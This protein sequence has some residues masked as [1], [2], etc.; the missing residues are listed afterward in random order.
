MALP[1]SLN[2]AYYPDGSLAETI[3]TTTSANGLDKTIVT[4]DGNGIV[5]ETETDNTVV[6]NDGST[7]ETLTDV[8]GSGVV[9]DTTVT[10]T[11]ATRHGAQRQP[12]QTVTI[13]RDP[14]GAGYTAAAGSGY[15]ECRWQPLGVHF[16]SQP[17][18]HADRARRFPR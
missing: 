1:R 6:N 11:G 9:Q 15:H 10:T 18:W 8:D 14:N 4:K 5:F 12:R 17:R 2:S 7:T 16:R 3:S 13:D